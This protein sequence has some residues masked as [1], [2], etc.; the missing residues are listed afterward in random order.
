MTRPRPIRTGRRIEVPVWLW[1]IFLI[2]G[3]C[4]TAQVYVEYLK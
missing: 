3:A 2:T 1:L 4:A